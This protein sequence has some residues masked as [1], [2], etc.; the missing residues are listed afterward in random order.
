MW[1]LWRNKSAARGSGFNKRGRERGPNGEDAVTKQD[2]KDLLNDIRFPSL[3]ASCAF[4]P[5]AQEFEALPAAMSTRPE[6]PNGNLLYFMRGRE[7]LL[8]HGQNVETGCHVT[9]FLSKKAVKLFQVAAGSTKSRSSP[10][11]HTSA[12]LNG[13]YEMRGVS[14]ATLRRLLPA[15][16][17]S[18]QP[19]SPSLHPPP[20]LITQ[21]GFCHH[22]S[23]LRF[24]QKGSSS[25]PPPSFSR[26]CQG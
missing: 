14:K 6:V 26:T 11:N 23:A 21:R 18:R 2:R 22:D 19:R 1:V 13:N 24:R 7:T 15:F 25:N 17:K 20:T 4:L 5:R 3:S 9:L 12:L 8:F 10:S 16:Y